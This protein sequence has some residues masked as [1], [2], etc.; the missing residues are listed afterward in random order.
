MTK[1]IFAIPIYFIFK[2]FYSN[3]IEQENKKKIFIV[4][5]TLLICFS[6]G[7]KFIAFFLSEVINILPDK[8]YNYLTIYSQ[9]FNINFFELAYKL[10]FCVSFVAAYLRNKETFKD[11]IPYFILFLI[12]LIIFPV[13]FSIKNADRLGYY[14]LY[15]SIL[16]IIPSI[17]YAFKDN[18]ILKNMTIIGTV[19]I[20]FIYWYRIYVVL[21]FS[22]T[23]PYSSDIFKILNI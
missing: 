14:Y 13:S 18:K 21:G 1:Y 3:K 9:E 12:D 2:L 10:F 5:L 19:I 17:A 6:L 7:Y 11:K 23:Y 20:L 4:L 16:L 8:Y 22:E 15:P